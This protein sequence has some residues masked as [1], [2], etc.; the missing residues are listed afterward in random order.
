M[1]RFFG[2]KQ[3]KKA[4]ALMPQHAL[5][6]DEDDYVVLRSGEDDSDAAFSNYPPPPSTSLQFSAPGFEKSFRYPPPSTT[7]MEQSRNVRR[8]KSSDGAEIGLSSPESSP[9]RASRRFSSPDRK[10]SASNH[11]SKAFL[12]ILKG[13]RLGGKGSAKPDVMPVD[14]PSSD[15]FSQLTFSEPFVSQH[16]LSP[17]NRARSKTVAPASESFTSTEWDPT[18]DVHSS[19]GLTPPVAEQAPTVSPSRRPKLKFRISS[20]PL[21]KSFSKPSPVP[22]PSVVHPQSTLPKE[23]FF[24]LDQV[25]DAAPFAWPESGQ[26]NVDWIAKEEGSELPF[27]D[28]KQ[29]IEAEASTEAE[30]SKIELPSSP[31]AVEIS[32]PSARDQKVKKQKK[33]SKTPTPTPALEEATDK[34][35]LHLGDED[36]QM[37]VSEPKEAKP[38]TRKESKTPIRTRSNEI[39]EEVMAVPS[40]E[41]EVV[42]K[43]KVSKKI[44]KEPKTPTRSKDAD[45]DPKTPSRSKDASAES[46]E[47]LK[48]KKSKDSS[49][50]EKAPKTPSK[51][52][53]KDLASSANPKAAKAK[54]STKDVS[55]PKKKEKRSKTPLP[56]DIRNQD[57]DNSEKISVDKP[58]K[59]PSK[60]R[61]S[62]KDQVLRSPQRIVSSER[63]D[64][65]M[66]GHS[67][68]PS[69]A[70]S[71]SRRRHSE[72]EPLAQETCVIE[73]PT[74]PT[75]RQRSPSKSR[76]PK[77]P[78][79]E[80]KRAH[81][82]GSNKV[83]KVPK[84][85][86]VEP[87]SSEIELP[88]QS[89]R[90]SSSPKK[91]L[92]AVN[93]PVDIP[94]DLVFPGDDSPMS[95]PKKNLQK[96]IS[97]SRENIPKYDDDGIDHPPKFSLSNL[98]ATNLQ[99][100]EEFSIDED[101]PEWVN[102]AYTMIENFRADTA[103]SAEM[104]SSAEGLGILADTLSSGS[105]SSLS[106]CADRIT[107]SPSND[108]YKSE[109]RVDDP[110][111]NDAAQTV[112]HDGGEDDEKSLGYR[113]EVKV[114]HAMHEK[115][116]NVWIAL[117]VDPEKPA[118]A[119]IH[120]E[121]TGNAENLGTT[122]TEA[123]STQTEEKLSFPVLSISKRDTAPSRSISNNFFEKTFVQR[124]ATPKRSKSHC[125]ALS[126]GHPMP[127]ESVPSAPA[128]VEK[129]TIVSEAKVSSAT[130]P[131]VSYP[132]ISLSKRDTTPT[133]RSF[134]G[135]MQNHLPPV[136]QNKKDID[137]NDGVTKEDVVLTGNKQR[138][139]ELRRLA[140]QVAN[141]P[142][143][144]EDEAD[145]CDV[146]PQR[147]GSK[148]QDR[149]SV[150]MA[151]D[152][153]PI[154]DTTMK[155]RNR[156]STAFRN[157]RRLAKR[158]ANEP[159]SDDDETV[160]N[161]TTALPP[162]EA[163]TGQPDSTPEDKE[164]TTKR[165][166]RLSR[167]RSAPI[168]ER[169][170]S[171][172]LA[173]QQLFLQKG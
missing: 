65:A 149:S 7:S 131:K 5:L 147:V 127:V 103:F 55:T 146:E 59:S 119:S 30:D 126:I 163:P 22:D 87:T 88:K 68:V 130:Q 157:L 8:H 56:S 138:F 83:A 115:P 124:D 160:H 66:T 44:D 17:E 110:N 133:R 117:K 71:R 135:D 136:H 38:K 82:I 53:T 118:H 108:N 33:E 75:H 28:V 114:E 61:S 104:K 140:K 144:S 4:S 159:L 99:V 45:R 79:E 43:T 101:V 169:F 62:E 89:S 15:L 139:R 151:A 76:E 111:D 170:E 12:P 137:K 27:V 153:E 20:E 142:T 166:I 122:P 85:S 48:A 106:T 173:G 81:G 21:S 1:N 47:V 168:T 155:R 154:T 29:T 13:R 73:V 39:S 74:K 24:S 58:P 14:Q 25:G 40:E 77:P 123:T 50:K 141:E 63:P 129:L 9:L 91:R 165:T 69:R 36:L 37:I 172:H 19:F 109:D 121:A 112:V 10:K 152:V 80:T 93:I 156:N 23:D 161:G 143:S 96:E 125:M 98:E 54:V 2:N 116:E 148:K 41:M 60:A 95:S 107:T 67:T 145:P 34:K 128:A 113:K 134:S 26:S 120:A 35:P 70:E 150:D 3:A 32:E 100:P 46:G 16:L 86:T 171:R 167:Q 6:D 72:K 132:S 49:D 11:L 97:P 162:D 102:K 18:H 42:I 51:K 164:S 78:K 84:G 31:V 105:C 52:E 92:S 90:K 64:A 158:A 94:N 57:I